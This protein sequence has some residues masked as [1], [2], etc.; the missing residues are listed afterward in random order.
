MPNLMQTLEDIFATVV[1][2][3]FQPEI[4]YTIWT[5]ISGRCD[6][7]WK[8][9]LEVNTPSYLCNVSYYKIIVLEYLK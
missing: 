7:N 1:N 9:E 8:L 6:S 5:N 2:S 3:T 4:N